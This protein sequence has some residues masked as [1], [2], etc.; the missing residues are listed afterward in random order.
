MVAAGN[1]GKLCSRMA[2]TPIARAYTTVYKP[3]WSYVCYREYVRERSLPLLYPFRATSAAIDPRR[4]SRAPLWTD[5]KRTTARLHFGA[6]VT[7]HRGTDGKLYVADT[8]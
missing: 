3:V 6:D 2:H 1:A 7:G 5:G 4:I 8:A